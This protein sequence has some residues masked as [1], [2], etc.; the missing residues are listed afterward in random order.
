MVPSTLVILTVLNQHRS[1]AIVYTVWV[2]ICLD[3][4]LFSFFLY[5]II[6]YCL[7]FHLLGLG[8]LL[9]LLL[10]QL[11]D[12]IGIVL[13][14]LVPLVR[15]LAGLGHLLED[16]VFLVGLGCEGGILAGKGD[17]EVFDIACVCLE[18]ALLVIIAQAW[19]RTREGQKLRLMKSG[20]RGTRRMGSSH[21]LCLGE[22]AVDGAGAAAAAHG[23]VV[24][25]FLRHVERVVLCLFVW[26]VCVC[27]VRM[28]IVG[29]N[30][31]CFYSRKSRCCS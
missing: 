2:F 6:A 25:E 21:T 1:P 12:L 13:G 15:S 14:P 9:C 20:R 23:D 11:L 7:D 27:G 29:R 16:G 19:K 5:N 31:Q 17:L 28:S 22:H 4:C 10:L 30:A 3:Y 26:S 18:G 24:L 8:S